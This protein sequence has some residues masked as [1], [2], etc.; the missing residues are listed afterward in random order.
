[1]TT[2]VTPQENHATGEPTTPADGRKKPAPTTPGP[3]PDENHATGNPADTRP[4][5]NHATG[6]GPA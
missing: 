5:E 3:R 4:Q 2:N 6:A 1:M